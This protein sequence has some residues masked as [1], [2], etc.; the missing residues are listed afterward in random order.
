MYSILFYL[1][2]EKDISTHMINEQKAFEIICNAILAE[3]DPTDDFKALAA[4]TPD[5]NEQ[6]RLVAQLIK[7]LFNLSMEKDRPSMEEKL[8]ADLYMAY[9]TTSWPH[10]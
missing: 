8:P 9:V 10:C 5:A 6:R 1:T 3:T 2:L 7:I 4:R